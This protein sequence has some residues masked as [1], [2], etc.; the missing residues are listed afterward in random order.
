MAAVRETEREREFSFIFRWVTK[1]R[2]VFCFVLH[3]SSSSGEEVVLDLRRD[4]VSPEDGKLCDGICGE[5]A[6]SCPCWFQFGFQS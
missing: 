4:F 2:S 1:S 5:K 6:L 3:L